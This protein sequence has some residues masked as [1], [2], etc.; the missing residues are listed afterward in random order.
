MDSCGELAPW[1]ENEA[2]DMKITLDPP[3]NSS[4]SQYHKHLKVSIINISNTAGGLKFKIS[5][6]FQRGIW[7]LSKTVWRPKTSCLFN[8]I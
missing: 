2:P 6:I 5:T 8:K 7:L 1:A 3:E 4:E